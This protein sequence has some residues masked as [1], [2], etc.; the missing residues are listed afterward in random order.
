MIAGTCCAAQLRRDVQLLA[1]RHP[2]PAPPLAVQDLQLDISFGGMVIAAV[3]VV[4][5]GLQQIFVRTMQQKHKLSAHELLS[6]T[7]PAQVRPALVGYLRA[8]RG[9]GPCTQ[10]LFT[11]TLCCPWQQSGNTYTF[12]LGVLRGAVGRALGRVVSLARA[13]LAMLL[14]QGLSLPH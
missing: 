3:S 4:S 9:C 8:G 12:T 13:A 10:A 2:A 1:C 7:A 6:N 11:C 5:S 14:R